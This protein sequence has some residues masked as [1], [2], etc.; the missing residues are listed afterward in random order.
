[1]HKFLIVGCG[2]SG[3][4]TLAY[5]MDQLKSDLAA[6]GVHSIPS[7][8]QFVH[9]D[10]PNA[11]DTRIPGMGNVA[12]QGGSYI[13]TGPQ[14]GS[15][16]VLDN[17]L[18]QTLG[19]AGA[20]EHLGTWAP[21]TPSD[22]KVAIGNGAGQMRAVGRA[23]TLS[24]SSAVADGLERAFQKLNTLETNAEMAD[25]ARR[26]PGVGRFDASSRPI[27]LVVSSMAGGAGA[28]MALDVCRLLALVPGVDPALTGVFMVT[29]D[30]FDALPE[31]MRGGVR[32]NALA[33]LGEIVA[34]QTNAAEE[35]DIAML[36]ALG[37]Q[38][39]PSGRAPFA[40]VFP[41][42]RFVGAERTLFGNGTQTAVYR[43]LGRGL[44]AL[45]S[46]GSAT[47]DFVEFDLINVSDP[48]PADADFLGWGAQSSSLPWGAFGF[49]S[50][51]M[52]RDRY[53]HYAAQRLA[54]TSADRL[55]TGHLQAGDTASG[56]VQITN[57]LNSQWSNISGALGLPQ[58]DG[59]APLTNPQV[60]SWFVTIAYPQGESAKAAQAIIETQFAPFVPLA[61]ATAAQ[62][63]AAL[64][65]FFVER[66][67]ALVGAVNDAAVTWCFDWSA[68]LHERV[69]RQVEAAVNEFGLP[70]ARALV[71]R[72]EAVCR[73]QLTA[74][75]GQLAA[76]ESADLGQ[77][78]PTFETEVAA[79]RGTIGNGPALI[80]RLANVVTTQVNAL[81]YARS[82]RTSRGLLEALLTDVLAPLRA[83]L[84]E[85]LA[86]LE[87]AAAAQVTAIGLANVATDQYAA[88]PSDDDNSV[89][90][91]FDVADNEILLTPSSGFSNQY[92]SDVQRSLGNDA[93]QLT[94][95]DARDRSARL[96]VTGL[97]PI[98]AG[99]EAPGGLLERLAEWRPALFGR[100]PRTGE[101]LTPSRARY[102]FH[103]TPADL[104][105]RALRFVERKNES[106]DTFCALS[107][108][109]YAEGRDIAPSA[110]LARTDDLVAKFN[111]ALHRALPLIS[112]NSDAVL[113]IHGSAMAY[114]YKFS[115][116]PF[117]DSGSVI[118]RLQ[119]TITGTANVA[120]ETTDAF[121][122]ALSDS[123]QL[124]RIDIF[125][126]YRNYS[127]LVFDSLLVPV[128]R[129][130]A[131]TPAMGRGEFWAHRRSR[132]LPASLPMGDTERRTMIAGWYVGQLTGQ[133][134]IPNAPY[135]RAVE[136]WDAENSRWLA[137]PHPLLTPPSQFLGRAIDWLPAVMESYLLAI[138]RA[139]DI[140]VMSSLRPYQLLRRLSDATR[141]VP[142]SGLQELSSE[143]TL[144]AWLTTGDT[145]SDLDSKVSGST[146]AE[147][148][149]RA[150]EWLGM[151][152]DYTGTN[153]LAPNQR[154]AAGHGAMSIIKTRRE[155]SATPIFRDLADDIFLVTGQ[156]TGVLD[157]ARERALRTGPDPFAAASRG[158]AAMDSAGNGPAVPEPNC[159][160]F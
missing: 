2:G 118:T 21:R 89:P 116:I 38:I 69:L 39:I 126:S 155:A 8:W 135:D 109:D 20:L 17:G 132:P 24:R 79:I 22:I 146:I 28:S 151:I 30:V 36:T 124:T 143:A 13:S 43:G 97:W 141:Q 123:R 53:R 65:R 14:S 105:D 75:L 142:A 127:P 114:R 160:S 112:V 117:L 42:G 31:S 7:G 12:A 82:A 100:N 32:P 113:A 23:I 62:W 131:A 77:L 60:M 78:P 70:Y 88:W 83:A 59:P 5:M 18:S 149:A 72:L 55:R 110:L 10:V 153:F 58:S 4:Q 91:R 64:R 40:R 129:Q 16:E 73:D 136:I 35:H 67:P 52:G 134:S 120:P 130:W 25:V 99:V 125:G 49:A 71:D 94:F 133:L 76:L 137:F 19:Q 152:H 90:D 122:R 56:V 108:R 48:S 111:E 98:S 147:R 68:G 1:M 11:P 95:P 66:K 156:L 87:L 27:V 85:S 106:F 46:S 144:A 9:V 74:H 84:S 29:P 119:E 148:H 115:S 96:V 3:G 92:R 121:S 54:R 157:R 159:G 33:M 15:Y 150:V 140:P 26:A 93:A 102:E 57:L 103:L 37:H 139:H 86:V 101:T 44:A 61:N 138:A 6:Q 50:L 51:S 128:S 41:V 107:L 104:L 34:T 45:V 81:I 145:P 158:S 63:L 47:G 154:G 80:S